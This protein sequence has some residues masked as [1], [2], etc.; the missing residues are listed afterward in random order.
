MCNSLQSLSPDVAAEWDY[1][2]N[3]GT[4]DDYPAYSGSK[5]WWYNDKRGSFQ[6][7]IGS[8]TYMRKDSGI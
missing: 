6:A 1:T 5:V 3:A 7:R 4:P 2:R 8:R